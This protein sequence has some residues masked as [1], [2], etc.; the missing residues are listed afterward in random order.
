MKDEDLICI[1]YIPKEHNM[2][3]LI[4]AKYDSEN[5]LRIVT[6]VTLGVSRQKMIQGGVRESSC[7]FTQVPDGHKDA[8]WLEPVVCTVE[9]MPSDKEGYRQAVFKGFRDDK[10]PDEC[11]I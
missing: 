5:Q 10:L 6:H 4:L 7:P 9:Y 3:S 8:I 1:G 2:T 11:F